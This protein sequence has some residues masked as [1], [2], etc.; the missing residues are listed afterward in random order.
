MPI[1]DMA[2]QRWL[3]DNEVTPPSPPEP[4]DMDLNERVAKLEVVLPTLATKEDLARLDGNLR[5]ELHKAIHD[6]TWKLISW[7]TGLGTALVAAA[8]FLARLPR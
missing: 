5:V 8:Y 7:T 4:P 3:A 2:S 6:Q 1:Y